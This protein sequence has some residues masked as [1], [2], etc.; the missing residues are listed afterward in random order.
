M[1]FGLLSQF[2]ILAVLIALAC[3]H[4]FMPIVLYQAWKSFKSEKPYDFS[5][6][7]CWV[8]PAF[9]LSCISIIIMFIFVTVP[10][11]FHSILAFSGGFE[12]QLI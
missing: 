7:S 2:Q 1:D 6:L 5:A 12:M 4:T 9:V 10:V 3:S 8:F 11:L